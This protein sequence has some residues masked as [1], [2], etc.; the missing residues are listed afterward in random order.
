MK[1]NPLMIPKI[2]GIFFVVSVLAACPDLPDFE[3]TTIDLSRLRPE[4]GKKHEEINK[5]N[6]SSQYDRTIEWYYYK[7]AE[8]YE[9][10]R[11]P[12]PG[13]KPP[14]GVPA[15]MP[16]NAEFGSD[17]TGNEPSGPDLTNAF[18]EARF[19][20]KPKEG[21]FF[22]VPNGNFTYIGADL[23][24]QLNTKNLIQVFVIFPEVE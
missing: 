17:G 13:T 5:K 1:K 14:S 3:I 12:E 15:K 8:E 18:Y 20:L 22:G 7:N 19:T 2:L 10:C 23:I 6:K 16:D 24:I 11:N 4:K 9:R 21:C